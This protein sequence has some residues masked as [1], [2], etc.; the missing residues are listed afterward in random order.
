M[1]NPDEPTFR[2]WLAIIG[3]CAFLTCVV[4]AGAM[5]IRNVG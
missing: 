2:L 4:M 5:A 1:T 3:G